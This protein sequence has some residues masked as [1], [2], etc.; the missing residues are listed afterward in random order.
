MKLGI[1]SCYFINNYGSILQSYATQEYLRSK[2]IDCDTVSVE[3]LKPYLY[4]KKKQYYLHSLLNPGLFLSKYSMLKLKIQQK[5]NFKKLGNS[6]RERVAKFDEF[7][8]K[9]ILSKKRGVI[10]GGINTTFL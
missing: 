8:K 4:S 3:K 10:F 5:I 6:Q 9:F 1:V 7:R 2:K